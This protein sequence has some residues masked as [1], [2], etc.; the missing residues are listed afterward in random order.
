M[1]PLDK[2]PSRVLIVDDEAKNLQILG[3]LLKDSGFDVALALGAEAALN[4]VRVRVPD[5]FLLD[6][7]M[8]GTD[9]FTLARQLR[10]LPQAAEVPILFISALSDEDSKVQAFEAGGVDYITKPFL[11]REV[12]ARV[13]SHLELKAYRDSLQTQ[14]DQRVLELETISLSLV[15]VLED[16][17][18]FRDNETG[19]HIHRVTEYSRILSQGYNLPDQTR[20]EIIR[21]ASLHDI[22]KVGVPDAILH[23]PGKLNDEEYAAMKTHVQKGFEIL[24]RPGIPQVARNLVLSHHEK[25]DGSGYPKGLKGEAIPVEARILAMADVY[26]ALRSPRVYKPA[27]SREKTESILREESGRHFDPQLVEFFQAHA[28]ELDDTCRRFGLL[29]S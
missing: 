1:K 23:K 20:K 28:D 25:W 4:S 15:A 3:R 14:V 21:Y 29:S 11:P 12:I 16:A 2:R 19:S 26:D 13:S 17:S 6:V 10:Q 27:F 9:G 24:N 7:M 5:L 8:P 22:G 18:S